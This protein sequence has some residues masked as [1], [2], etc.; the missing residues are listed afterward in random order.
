LLV[1]EV[2]CVSA[3]PDPSVGSAAREAFQIGQI[4]LDRVL[5]QSGGDRYYGRRL[6]GD[7]SEAGLTNIDSEGQTKMMRGGGPLAELQRLTAQQAREQLLRVGGLSALEAD[8]F[9]DLY[10]DPGF[11]WM[12]NTIMSVW[13]QRPIR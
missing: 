4:G 5:A 3:V 1:E 7:V 6:Y 10:A 2:D 13:G 11:I 12:G 9:I 8:A